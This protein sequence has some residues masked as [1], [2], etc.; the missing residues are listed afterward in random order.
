VLR[1]GEQIVY[2][3][4]DN[5]ETNNKGYVIFTECGYWEH[6]VEGS[7]HECEADHRDQYGGVDDA[8]EV[9]DVFHLTDDKADLLSWVTVS[10]NEC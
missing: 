2:Q 9:P 10:G 1:R 7:D 3:L 4:R 8:R 5:G 6:N